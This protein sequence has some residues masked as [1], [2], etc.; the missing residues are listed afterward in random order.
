MKVRHVFL[1]TEMVN[2]HVSWSKNRPRD[3]MKQ[4]FPI[5]SGVTLASLS[6][7]LLCFMSNF[8]YDSPIERQ[9]NNREGRVFIHC[10]DDDSSGFHSYVKYQEDC[11]DRSSMHLSL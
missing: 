4:H 10:E 2:W 11:G 9:Q 3:I 8:W 7:R 1:L 6:A 5:L